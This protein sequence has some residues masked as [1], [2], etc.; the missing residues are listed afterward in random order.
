MCAAITRWVQYDPTSSG[1]ADD[2]DGLKCLGTKGVCIGTDTVSD[3]ITI[4]PTTNTLDLTF[5]GAN[6]GQITLY[7]GADLDP[8]FI[9]KDITEKMHSYGVISKASDP[10]WTHATCKWENAWVTNPSVATYGNRFK[11]YSG[12]LGSSSSITVTGTASNVLGFDVQVSPGGTAENTTGST[13]TE[14]VEATLSGTYQGLFDETYKV[15]VSNENNGAGPTR[16]IDTPTIQGGNTYNGTM[17]TGGVYNATADLLYTLAIDITNG[18]TMGGG[19]G[20]VPILSWTSGG[21]VDDSGPTHTELLYVG[22]W[23]SVG[24]RGL[25]VKFTDAV[26]NTASP[27]WTIQCRAPDYAEG[28]NTSADIGGSNPAEYVW[29]SD[30]GDMSA[31]P[32]ATAS[33]TFTQ[34]GTRGMYIKFTPTTPGNQLTIRDEFFVTCAGPIPSAYNITSLNYGNVTVSTES[35]VKTVMFE[36][37]SG[38]VEISTVKFGLQSHGTFDYHDATPFDTEFRFGT[39]G[40]GDE[41]YGGTGIN[42]GIEWPTGITAANLDLGTNLLNDTVDD[43]AEV[44]NADDSTA[45]GSL[46]LVSNPIWLCIRLGASETGANSSINHR[47]YFDYS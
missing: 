27:A 38:A 12:T 23:Y 15:V 46:G 4:G 3:A 30:R 8:R 29:S 43:L 6:N 7:S 16:G 39:V 13:N 21:G 31:T 14:S 33:G 42:N 35:P 22:H 5:D 18:S 1:S 28:T 41:A 10:T 37:E 45:V 20:N 9:A 17:A 11:V 32:V 44:Q 36:V 2:G 47:L 26:F 25:M 19:S 24:T 34:L 40:P